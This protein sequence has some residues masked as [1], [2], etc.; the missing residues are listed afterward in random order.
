M[1]VP[2]SLAVTYSRG[3]YNFARFALCCNRLCDWMEITTTGRWIPLQISV[4]SGTLVCTVRDKS[5]IFSKRNISWV[6]SIQDFH[7]TWTWFRIIWLV[8]KWQSPEIYF[9]CPWM[10]T[11]LQEKK[12]GKNRKDRRRRCH[13]EVQ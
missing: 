7:C 10:V 11:K 3:K 5:Y 1:R 8:S 2:V 13:V 6:L 9:L 4:S 12:S